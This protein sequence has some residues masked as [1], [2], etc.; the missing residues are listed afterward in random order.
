ME[1]IAARQVPLSQL[2]VAEWNPN[3]ATDATIAKIRNSIE[4][5]GFVENLV[6]RQHP[7]EKGAFEVL[8]GNHRLE[9]LRELGVK[10]VQVVIV[11]VDDARARILA[12]TLN[13]TRGRDDPL[14]YRRLIDD[15]LQVLPIGDITS[16]LPEDE[17]SLENVLGTLEAPEIE[18]PEVWGVIVDC[19]D[20]GEEQ[21]LLERFRSEGR[22]CRQLLVRAA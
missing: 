10:K 14:I 5:F 2:R 16:L 13:R 7:S 6:A 20:E 9:I 8:S 11:E 3:Q 15:L 1:M 17:R 21:E 12:Q 18:I 22:E 4:Q 19:R